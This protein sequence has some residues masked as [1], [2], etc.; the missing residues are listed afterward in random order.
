MDHGALEAEAESWHAKMQ[1]VPL[2]PA[3]VLQAMQFAQRDNPRMYSLMRI[4]LPRGQLGADELR[5]LCSHLSI[6]AHNHGIELS[7]AEFQERLDR[8]RAA[9]RTGIRPCAC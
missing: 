2:V 8:Q 6:V 1:Q 7:A 9:V 5:A 3:D 4:G